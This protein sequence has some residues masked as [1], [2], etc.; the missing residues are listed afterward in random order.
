MGNTNVPV[1]KRDF[2]LDL[3]ALDGQG[4]YAAR[5]LRAAIRDYAMTHGVAA[6]KST[7]GAVNSANTAPALP[8]NSVAPSI[9]GTPAVGQVLTGVDGTWTNGY[10]ATVTTKRQWYRD[11]AAIA[12]ATGQT[13]TLTAA[14]E[15]AV[16]KFG[17]TKSNASGATAV[18]SNP[19]ATVTA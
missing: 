1:A 6:L 3:S 15:G 8:D 18:L 16:I 11:G 17:V 19:T 10:P 2:Y 5:E 9:T 7:L 12:G 4:S 13:Y 14:D